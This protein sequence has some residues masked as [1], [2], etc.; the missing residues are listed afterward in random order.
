LIYE[1]KDIEKLTLE[2]A[3]SIAEKARYFK[4]N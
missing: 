4:K 2:G 1:R 3:I